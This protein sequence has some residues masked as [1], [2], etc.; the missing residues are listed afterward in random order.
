MDALC[1]L[2][3][4]ALG[5]SPVTSYSGVKRGEVPHSARQVP[6]TAAL[7]GTCADAPSSLEVSLGASNLPESSSSSSAH[8]WHDLKARHDVFGAGRTCNNVVTNCVVSIQ[9]IY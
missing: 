5:I 1:A 4:C 9:T 3:V 6:C 2:H 7:P 8:A